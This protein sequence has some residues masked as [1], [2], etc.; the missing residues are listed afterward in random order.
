M[1]KKYPIIMNANIININT[2]NIINT[3]YLA[4]YLYTLPK[5]LSVHA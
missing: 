4:L 1:Y 3:L 2:T 5:P